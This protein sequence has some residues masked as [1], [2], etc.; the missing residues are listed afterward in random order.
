M[1]IRDSLASLIND[2]KWELLTE[3]SSPVQLS[4]NR[5]QFTVPENNP[6]CVTIT[7]SF[8]TFFRVSI[9]FPAEITA[10]KALEIC[11]KVCPTIR[12]TVLTSIRKAS[13][14]LNYKN[15]IPKAAFL[16]NN[17]KHEATS[18]HPASISGAGLLTC[19]THPRSVFSEMTKQHKLWIE[20]APFPD[21]SGE[22][23]ALVELTIKDLRKVLRA[24]WGARAKWYY[25]GLELDIDPGTLNSIK[26]NN[27]NNEDRLSA[28]LT[29]W[30]NMAQ[31]KPTWAALTEALQSPTV[32]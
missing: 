7:D 12:E 17:S 13:R 15:S 11:E 4:R 8:S 32:G 20:K 25:I 29:T 30:L 9:E 1:C 18:L 26:G 19:T 24:T 22:P 27:D 10:E 21:F 23:A 2:A 28:M 5:A 6:G 31:P 14:R 3:N 16:C